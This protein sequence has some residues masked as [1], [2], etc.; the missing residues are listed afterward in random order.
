MRSERW[1]WLPGFCGLAFLIHIGIL[2]HI[3]F[4]SP[5]IN[6]TKP[7]EIE[8]TLEPRPTPPEPKP[9]PEPEKPPV[10]RPT[11]STA[12][13]RLARSAMPAR[14]RLIKVV[15]R[16]RV[17][18]RRSVRV[19]SADTMQ[20]GP[21]TVNEDTSV[22]ERP[23]KLS[24]ERPTT[25]RLVSGTR[26]VQQKRLERL[27][28]RGPL[29]GGGATAPTPAS[30]LRGSVTS[31]QAP[32]ERVAYNASRAHAERLDSS[33][34]RMGNPGT[35][36]LSANGNLLAGATLPD[37]RPDLSGLPARR[38]ASGTPGLR[39]LAK[40]SS[41]L[42][43]GGSPAAG[44]SANIYSG[45]KSPEAPSV[46]GSYGGSHAG[47]QRLSINAPRMLGGGGSTILTAS[48]PLAKDAV[49]D[50][51]PGLGPGIGGGG[52]GRGTGHGA[53][54][55]LRGNPGIGG[56]ASGYGGGG[57]TTGRGRG[58]L[59]EQPGAH[60]A[61]TGYGG[62]AG[63][64]AGHQGSDG[65]PGTP[66]L[67]GRSV[68]PGGS[69]LARDATPNDRPGSGPGGGGSGKGSGRGGRAIASLHGDGGLG[70][71]TDGNG[72]GG[73]IR[74]G[75]MAGSGR[76]VGAEEL[77]PGKARYGRGRGLASDGS[78]AMVRA[79]P[80]GDGPDLLG[81]NGLGKALRPKRTGGG[82][83]H[84]IYL[85]DT[86][87]S[88]HEANKIGKAKLAL[89]KALDELLPADTFNIISFDKEIHVFDADLVLATDENIQRAKDYVKGINARDMTYLSGAMEAA[90][91]MKRANQMFVMSD[92]EPDVGIENFDELRRFVR[93]RNTGHVMINTLALG[94]GERFM[95]MRLLKSLAEENNGKFDYVNL[96]K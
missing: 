17:V 73:S 18:V 50:D 94:T 83:V 29:A 74:G 31:P 15:R 82:A 37:D 47:G 5:A 56:I 2:I 72:S 24:G 54:S 91:S 59:A 58:Q 28:H 27:L 1:Y 52:A 77:G 41:S 87:A 9:T 43:G 92:G 70:G 79:V 86:S 49:P 22:R 88:M 38:G 40:T 16:P 90:L 20:S 36:A 62:G 81:I 60:G 12:P 14:P 32:S 63:T 35:R 7:T 8:V 48:N 25:R 26:D 4:F 95:G 44:R 46:A 57:G 71:I 34:P 39:N 78:G 76:G 75:G 68:L 33:A 51:R 93:S 65:L 3:R 21:D 6:V 84:V 64:G 69:L 85:L 30:R 42:P 55:K 23:N 13:M 89:Q 66:G 53:L 19:A 80:F 96:A 67:K 61:G 11:L 10:V 45:A